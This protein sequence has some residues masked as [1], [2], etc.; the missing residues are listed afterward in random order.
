M[1]IWTAFANQYWPAD[2][3]YGRDGRQASVHFGEGDYAKTENELRALL[4]VDRSSPRS[5][6]HGHEGGSATTADITAETYNGS[7][8]GQELYSSGQPLVDGENTFTVGTKLPP[9]AHGLDGRWRVRGQYVESLGPGAAVV[10]GYRAGQV[11]LV[12]STA[13][14]APIP[15]TVQVDDG[16][17]TTV[18][19]ADADLY[20]LVD[21]P[22]IGTHTVRVTATAPGLRAFAFTFGG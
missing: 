18:T 1:T 20:N 14:G 2:Y 21:D 19:V 15:V 11:N 4:G 12:M 3:I 13:T 10:L 8:R 6:P 7:E 22:S 16:R 17:P 5:T 9:G